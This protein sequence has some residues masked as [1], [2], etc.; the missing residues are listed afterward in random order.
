M[1]A[2]NIGRYWM[3]LESANGAQKMQRTI[4]LVH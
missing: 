1:I 3:W 4:Y 2:R